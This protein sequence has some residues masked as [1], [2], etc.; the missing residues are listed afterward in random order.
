MFS[1]IYRPAVQRVLGAASVSIIPKNGRRS[2]TA[3]HRARWLGVGFCHSAFSRA[4][5][6]GDPSRLA[7]QTRSGIASILGNHYVSITGLSRIYHGT[8]MEPLGNYHG[9]SVGIKYW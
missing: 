3:T 4:V 7:W 8:I 5:W 1:G 2:R 6:V 9:T